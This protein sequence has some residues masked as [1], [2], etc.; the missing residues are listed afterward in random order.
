MVVSVWF[1]SEESVALFYSDDDDDDDGCV[2]GSRQCSS[3][4]DDV[5][6]IIVVVFCMYDGEEG[7]VESERE[8]GG[9]RERGSAIRASDSCKRTNTY[10]MQQHIIPR[11]NILSLLK[12]I[13]RTRASVSR[14]GL[15]NLFHRHTRRVTFQALTIKIK[16]RVLY[17]NVRH[18]LFLCEKNQY[19]K[20]GATSI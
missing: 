9:R 14:T 1:V 18:L 10:C 6:F 17:I 5:G 3:G 16:D 7:G 11:H 2:V 12:S 20:K 19:K 8:R 4:R 15:C 13:L